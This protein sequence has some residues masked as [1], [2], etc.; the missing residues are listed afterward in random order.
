M[1][2]DVDIRLGTIFLPYLEDLSEEHVADYIFTY[3]DKCMRI[4]G[5]RRL[6]K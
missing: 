2:M 5:R 1:N 6:F 3:V 4:L